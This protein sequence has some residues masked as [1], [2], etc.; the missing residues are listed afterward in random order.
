MMIDREFTVRIVSF[1]YFIYLGAPRSVALLQQFVHFI[2]LIRSACG[3][4]LNAGR[5]YA[6]WRRARLRSGIVCYS[7]V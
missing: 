7:S 4:S 2:R 5:A 1:G 3:S 6:C